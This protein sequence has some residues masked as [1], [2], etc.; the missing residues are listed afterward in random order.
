MHQCGYYRSREFY[1][2]QDIILNT[3]YMK[4][5]PCKLRTKLNSDK[6]VLESIYNNTFIK[7]IDLQSNELNYETVYPIHYLMSLP[8]IITN[9]DNIR[10]EHDIICN[11]FHFLE[12]LNQNKIEFKYDSLIVI[13]NIPDLDNAFWN[14]FYLSFGNGTKNNTAFVSSAI[15][16]H[17]LSHAL[18]QQI[19]DLEYQGQSGSLNESF[20]DIIGVCFEFYMREKFQSLGWEL[21]SETG[22]K[23]RD[24]QEPHRCKQPIYVNDLYYVNPDSY[25]DNGGVHINSGIPNHMFYKIQCYIGWR[26]SFDFF[27][28]V[29]RRLTRFSQFKDFA[30]ELLFVNSNCNYLNNELLLSIINKHIN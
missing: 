29:L 16:G 27:I 6:I 2:L 5:V 11:I 24:L 19:N 26:K 14:G 20:A 28:K 10:Y 1:K 7:L 18:I 4:K 17:E 9:P 25:E 3:Y 8:S 15:C 21:A 13:C 12:F 23:L 30:N 22:M